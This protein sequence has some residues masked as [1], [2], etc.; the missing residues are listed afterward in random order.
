MGISSGKGEMSGVRGENGETP[1]PDGHGKRLR[2]R[3]SVFPAPRIF[4]LL[5]LYAL[6]PLTS[7]V[8]C[9]GNLIPNPGFVVSEGDGLPYF[10]RHGESV[11]EVVKRSEFSSGPAGSPPLRA[12]GIKGGED[13]SG[14][15]RCLVEGLEKGGRYRLSFAVYRDHYAEGF[16]P[17]IELFGARMRLSNL[18]TYGSWQNFGIVFTAPGDSTVLRFINDYPVAFYFASPVLEKIQ[19]QE[20]EGDAPA[21]AVKGRE[22]LMPDFFPLVAYGA[23]RADFAF[24]RDMGF[25]AAVAWLS[26]D[27][28][29]ETLSDAGEHGLR[30]VASPRDEAAIRKISSPAAAH[31]LLGWYVEDEPEGRSVPPDVIMDRVKKIRDA[32]SV[33]PTFMAMVRPEFVKAYKGIAD[34]ILMDQYPI[35]HNPLIWLS[36]SMDEAGH[37]GQDSVWAV[38]QIFGGQG[39][40]GMG[41]DRE[42]T[43]DEMRAL[44]Y[45]A[46]VHGAGGLFFYT[47]KDGRYDVR[48]D[49]GH[50]EDVRR[51]IQE[52]R[53]L[54]P[55][56]LFQ[57]AGAPGFFSDSLYAFAPDG[58]KPVHARTLRDGKRLI[59]I[60]VNV[61]DREVRGRL[62]EIG[63]GIPYLDEY[64]S[65][66]RYVVKDRNIVDEFRPYEAKIYFAGKDF[67]KVR[68]VDG[69]NGAVKGKFYAEVAASDHEQI[70]GL[71]FRDL[72]A[73][74]RALLFPN[75]KNAEMKIRG[76]NVK[77]PF[78][79]LFFDRDYRVS[80]LYRD[81]RPC[82]EAASCRNYSSPVPARAA[83]EVKAGVTEKLGIEEGDRLEFY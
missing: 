57:A 41:W 8:Y 27:S 5:T 24:L 47:V 67:R 82:K 22:V 2:V 61:L 16:F 77:S 54:G 70:A 74:D 36:K 14:D 19:G 64:F 53:F 49:P 63:D 9:A 45:L 1:H 60:A 40:T 12:L 72:Q 55:L 78:D 58:T 56:Y 26:A 6:S 80:A 11:T 30:I 28:A 59:V 43:Y 13:R 69:G 37:A 32:G 48:A 17:E 51:L 21:A 65:G 68:I 33:A 20:L 25:N 76:L 79:I 62:T 4:L 81:A 50:L 73:E 75:E 38:I 46:I 34:V 66:K 42:P 29:E 3:F 71:M 52:L 15:W 10:W 35:P 83:L 23:K 18:L 44:S 7:Q 39:W 31:A